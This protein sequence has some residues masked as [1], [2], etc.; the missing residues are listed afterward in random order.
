MVPIPV[1]ITASQLKLEIPQ[2]G[3]PVASVVAVNRYKEPQ[4]KIFIVMD[5][6]QHESPASDH[7]VHIPLPPLSS[8]LNQ[9]L[10]SRVAATWVA[11]RVSVLGF[12]ALREKMM[13][14]SWLELFAVVDAV[15]CIVCLLWM[16]V[17]N[18]RHDMFN[19]HGKKEEKVKLD[20]EFRL[21]RSFADQIRGNF[22]HLVTFKQGRG[23]LVWIEILPLLCG[24]VNNWYG[25][26]PIYSEC[27]EGRIKSGDE[28]Y[29]K[30][31]W[32]KLSKI[33]G[34]KKIDVELDEWRRDGGGK[35]KSNERS[36]Q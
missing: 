22:V 13:T 26:A 34:R 12:R 19:L 21:S 29:G 36:A 7:Q 4:I 35:G 1:V 27:W 31:G 10:I 2:G 14:G 11:E 8:V 23:R 25:N 18:N 30:D 33:I 28:F 9:Y 32:T 15:R 6:Y 3:I 17:R 16:K 20:L 24:K 5:I